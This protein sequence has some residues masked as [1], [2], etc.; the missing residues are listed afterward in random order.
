MTDS[1]K[2][3]FSAHS[4]IYAKYRPLYPKDLYDFIFRHLPSKEK[5][6]DCGTGNGQAASVLSEHFKLVHAID[7]SQNQ[8]VNATQRGNLHYHVCKAEE[9]PFDDNTF[10]LITSATA[11]H[12]FQFDKFF[13][14]MKRIGRNNAIFACWAYKVLRTDHT[15][16]DKIIDKFY[17][18]TIHSYWDSERR[19]VDEE[20][21]TIAFPFEEITNPGFATCVSWDMEI[22]EGY[23]NTWSA[24]QHYIKKNNINPVNALMKEIRAA[25]GDDIQL[26]ITLPIFMRIGTIRK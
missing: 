25:V 13:K 3:L 5:A 1:A 4:D 14:E 7:I 26:S 22:L 23:V 15:L 10:D 16:L 11:V 19:H 12:W 17:G 18:E 9:T 24:V 6:L 2:D 21:K 20:Y 8:I